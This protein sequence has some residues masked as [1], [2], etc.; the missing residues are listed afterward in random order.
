MIIKEN[1]EE[2]KETLIRSGLV[3]FNLHRM[4]KGSR[5]DQPN[6]IPGRRNRY[7]LSIIKQ[8]YRR[9]EEELTNLKNKN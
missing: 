7:F 5:S 8:N 6:E 9:I 3:F 1:I 4:E 2:I